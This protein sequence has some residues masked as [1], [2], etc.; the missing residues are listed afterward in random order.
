MTRRPGIRLTEAQRLDWLRLT[1]AEGVGPL[2]FKALINRFGSAAAALEGLPELARRKGRGDIRVPSRSEA[3]RELTIAAGLGA[4]FIGL[5]EPDYP[6]LLR[7]SD[8]A[9]PLLAVIGDAAVL[10]RPAVAVVGS[11][12]A[13]GA[14]RT[15]TGRLA[16]ALTQQGLVVVSGLARGIDT[17]AHE[18]ALDFATVAVMAGGLDRPY[19][20]ENLDLYRRI[21]E[22]GAAVS[23][24]PFGW[25]PRG[26][27]FP[28]RNRI[29][30]GLAYG[31][32]VI[33]AARKSGSLITARFAA[34]QG[35]EVFAVPGSPLDPRAEGAND[36]IRNGATLCTGVE[37]V[38]RVL[39]PMIEAPDLF[40]ERVAG[41]EP[42]RPTYRNEPLWDELIDDDGA[43]PQ[44]ELFG[45]AF[46]DSAPEATFLAG[47][48][49]AAGRVVAALGPAPLDI[50]DVA[51]VAG[52]SARDLHRVLLDLELAGRIERHG[53]GRVSLLPGDEV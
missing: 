25:V 24:M 34:E 32:V 1:R 3:E 46:E 41:E 26:R 15:F 22:R 8:G 48:D 14:G 53:G 36:L 17:Q 27:D 28:R 47:S 10:A 9:P 50:D 43:A 4:R 7:A 16:K 37:D 29:I 52:V 18:A 19:P 20:P 31:V 38:V 11:R 40:A 13:S 6:A 39:G 44:A 49:D 23:E 51:R 35:R 12:N 2:T 42:G 5:G 30:S 21:G 45:E 33:E